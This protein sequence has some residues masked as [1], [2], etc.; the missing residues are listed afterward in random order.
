MNE[1]DHAL[2]QPQR[3]PNNQTSNEDDVVQTA[4]WT[5]GRKCCKSACITPSG[6]QDC[7]HQCT[8]MTELVVY[9]LRNVQPVQLRMQQIWQT[10]LVCRSQCKQQHS[11]LV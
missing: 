11:V 7:R 5:A 6:R 3:K 8:L 1:S 9:S 10:V 2:G 4:G